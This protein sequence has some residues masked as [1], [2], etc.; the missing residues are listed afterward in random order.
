[1]KTIVYLILGLLL[2]N[3]GGIP[4]YKDGNQRFLTN[5]KLIEGE[6]NNYNN[7]SLKLRGN[8]I[9]SKINWRKKRL[10]TTRY[11]SVKIKILNEKQLR[12]DFIKNDSTLKSQT[13][14]YRLRKDGFIKLR[15]NNLQ[16]VGVPWLFG[17]Y[18][19][20]MYDLGLTKTDDLIL[21]GY[22]EEAAAVMVALFAG[23][24]YDIKNIY[25]RR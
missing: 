11:T 1:M 12:F 18:K 6:Y 9:N 22:S 3:C 4:K 10:D 13:F 25:K 7:D 21:H 5:P 8:S 24:R 15:N 19:N 16:V 2:C 14:K 23:R 17:G 20:V